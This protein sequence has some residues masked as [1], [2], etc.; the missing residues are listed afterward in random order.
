VRG[1]SR[2][3]AGTSRTSRRRLALASILVCVLA[4]CAPPDLQPG[5]PPDGE[6][7]GEATGEEGREATAEEGGPEP[8]PE[9]SPLPEPAPDD[10]LEPDRDRLGPPVTI[11]FAGDV[12]F[13][14]MIRPQLDADPEG[15]L[16]PIAPVFAAADLTVVNLETAIT[17][18]G[19]PEPK[20]FVFRAPPTALDALDA[21]GVDAA[22]L[23]NNHG[24][25]FGQVGLEDTLA[26]G[27]E[28]QVELIGAGQDIGEAFA[29]FTARVRGRDVAVIAATQVM[30]TVFHDTWPATEDR[31]G[32]AF[33]KHEHEQDLLDAVVAAKREHDIVAVF[34]HWGFEGEH[35]PSDRQMG[36]ARALADAEADVVVGTHAHRLQGAGMLDDTLVHYGLGN[37]VFYAQ[38]GP[39]T[40]SGVLQVTVDT[41]GVLGYEW[42]PARIREGIPHPLEGDDAATA[43]AAWEELRGC[44]D[45][46]A[47]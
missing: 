4:A 46:S 37:F 42:V 7:G 38:T 39:G 44:T 29:P 3:V 9:A 5:S 6:E 32:M 25:D 30:D 23:A 20:S 16:D 31:P 18:G 19:T 47:D 35:C 24:L 13:E 2:P 40:D 8:G 28:A 34:L 41:Q 15:L 11:A 12:M 45:L 10:A 21:A 26:A 14:G 22:S 33:A 27:R 17:T 1:T 36:L 43:V